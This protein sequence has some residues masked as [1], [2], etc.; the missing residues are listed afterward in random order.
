MARLKKVNGYGLDV[1]ERYL[2]DDTLT[3]PDGNVIE[4]GD[5][6]KIRGKNSFGVGE[7]GLMFKFNYLVTDTK[8]GNIYVECFEMFRGRAGVMRAF[9]IERI[10]RIP[11]KRS[12]RVRRTAD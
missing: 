12:K 11:K 10:K 5:M 9:P 2:R 4:R 8:S 7:W 3:L 6:F 1:S